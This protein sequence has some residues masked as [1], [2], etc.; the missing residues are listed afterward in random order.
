MRPAVDLSALTLRDLLFLEAVLAGVVAARERSPEADV[1][2]MVEDDCVGLVVS[3][4]RE[5]P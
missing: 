2:V 4:P 5:G 1:S 3:L